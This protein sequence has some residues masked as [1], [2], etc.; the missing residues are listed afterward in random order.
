MNGGDEV[1]DAYVKKKDAL[2]LSP[3]FI[4]FSLQYTQTLTQ[5]EYK[6]GGV[7]LMKRSTAHKAI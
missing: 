3:L 7:T 2:S 4:S 6:G 5:N 1:E